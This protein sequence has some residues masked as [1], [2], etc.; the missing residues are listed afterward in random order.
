M[1]KYFLI[2][3]LNNINNLQSQQKLT[4]NLYLGIPLM[5]SEN[6]ID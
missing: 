5:S 3:I 6:F 2:Y 4:V 1:Y